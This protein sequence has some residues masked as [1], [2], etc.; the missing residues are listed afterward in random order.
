[1]IIERDVQVQ[2]RDGVALA[3]DV[4]RPDDGGQHPA[5]LQRNPYGKTHPLYV[6]GTTLDVIVA[7]QDGYAVVSQ[8]ARGRFES[9]GDWDPFRHETDDGF[10]SV[11][12]VGEQDWCNGRVGAFGTSYNGATALH[13]A[14]AKPKHLTAVVSYMAGTSYDDGWVYSGGAFELGFA[15]FWLT[16]GAW[17]TLRRRDLPQARRDELT[18][19][20]RSVA[21]FPRRI[22]DHLPV[23][24]MPAFVEELVPFWRDWLEHPPGS[25]YW[26]QIDVAAHAEQIEVP[27]L[28]ISGLYDNLL[29]GH[30]A[31]NEALKQHSSRLVR[32]QH[33]FVLGPWDH[34]AYQSSRPSAAGDWDFGPQAPNAY[35]LMRTMSREW[36][37][38]WLRGDDTPLLRTPRARFFRTGAETWEQADAWPPPHEQTDLYLHSG[39]HANTRSGDGQLDWKAP[40]GEQAADRF[41]YDPW[42]PVPSNGGRTLAPVFGTAG[43]HDQAAIEDRP[44]VLVYSTGRLER[45]L[46][47]AGEASVVLFASSSCV[48]TDFTA[49]LIDV[50]PDGY[51]RNIA[52]GIVRARYRAG[53]GSESLLVPDEPT[54]FRIDLRAVSHRFAPGH[55]VRL[56]VS[57]S[58][59][60]TYDRNLNSEAHPAFGGE[61]DVQVARQRV[62]HDAQHPT[63]LSI[64]LVGSRA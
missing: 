25:D 37:D 64:P 34:E 3:A 55:R 44:D 27:I 36:F 60:P 26:R 17:E 47:L 62:Y 39:G 24:E 63:R 45:E 13:M 30:L 5:L 40:S 57:S 54:E 4:Y 49:K 23:S 21:A 8:D 33:R 10:D 38:H 52:A 61:A 18:Q 29:G 59:F 50:E 31:L 42:D 32:E 22:V 6:H 1:M 15:V 20:L 58:N 43:I 53:D 28:H 51:C 19:L 2:M 7:V 12:W 16:R 14:I 41:R 35:G 48:D 11:E 9:G 56:E 46:I